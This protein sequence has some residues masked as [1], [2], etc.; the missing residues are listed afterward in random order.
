[1]TA[2]IVLSGKTERSKP[3][4]ILPGGHAAMAAAARPGTADCLTG[5]AGTHPV[6]MRLRLASA[7]SI[8]IAEGISVTAAPGWT[9]VNRGRTG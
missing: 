2:A 8:D 3:P 4:S 9:L 1:M 7:E 5:S 6:T